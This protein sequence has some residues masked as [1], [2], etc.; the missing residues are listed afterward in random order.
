[1]VERVG[2]VTLRMNTV[3]LVNDN[4]FGPRGTLTLDLNGSI[5]TGPENSFNVHVR[6]EMEKISLPYVSRD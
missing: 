3:L 2:Q 5:N 6:N 4:Q 1:M